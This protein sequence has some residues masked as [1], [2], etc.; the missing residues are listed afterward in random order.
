MASGER[1]LPVSL[2]F[3]PGSYFEPVP[4]F[5]SM[6]ICCQGVGINHAAGSMHRVGAQT[7]FGLR[8][9]GSIGGGC[10]PNESKE[11]LAHGPRLVKSLARG[12]VGW[13]QPTI[14]P[15]VAVGCTHPTP[16]ADTNL[17]P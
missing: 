1:Q 16:E 2:T 10:Y 9:T 12:F 14:R 8:W 4:E 11:N 15:G 7:V 17:G 13:V 5:I 6:M 3:K